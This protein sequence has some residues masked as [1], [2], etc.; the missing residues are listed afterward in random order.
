[1][2][3]PAAHGGFG[4]TGERPLPAHVL[5]A[6]QRGR[7]EL[8]LATEPGGEAIEIVAAKPKRKRRGVMNKTERAYSV[9]LEARKRCG[10]LTWWKF[11]SMPLVLAS[12]AS[13]MP[14]FAVKLTDGSLEFHEVK[15]G[16]IRE[17]AMVR[18]KVAARLYPFTFVLVQYVRGE[19]T[20]KTVSP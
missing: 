10:E 17:A 16:H 2:V 8:R 7:G 6:A 4:V 20:K 18:L 14:D 9:E 12:G 5:A 1:M 19:Q 11:E 3:A 15:G 13:F